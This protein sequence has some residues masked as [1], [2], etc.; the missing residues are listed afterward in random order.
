[1]RR[2]GVIHGACKMALRGHHLKRSLILQHVRLRHGRGACR[3]KERWVI[4]EKLEAK[5]RNN[6]ARMNGMEVGVST[7][8]NQTHES[9]LQFDKEAAEGEA[10]GMGTRGRSCCDHRLMKGRTGREAD[11]LAAA[12][13]Y[14]LA[15]GGVGGGPFE[16]GYVQ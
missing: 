5:E 10:G 4:N 1:M 15:W 8:G 13:D 9:H 3:R 6:A 7:V 11:C 2:R 16:R 14:R 12:A